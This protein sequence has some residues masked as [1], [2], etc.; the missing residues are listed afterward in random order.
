MNRSIDPTVAAQATE[1]LLSH[2]YRV[3]LSKALNPLNARD[4][5]VI[6]RR[7]QEALAGAVVGEE[8]I[9]IRAALSKLDVDWSRMTETQRAKIIQAS[10]SV[11]AQVP[12][13]VI[14]AIE[15]VL[16]VHGEKIIG[17]TK[18]ATKNQYKLKVTADL[19][20]TDK[21][22]L[23][24]MSSNQNLY[25]RDEYGRRQDRFA[26]TAI[27][28]VEGG[29]A[30][31]VGRDVIGARLETE[32]TQQGVNK[33]RSYWNM[34]ASTF[35][36]RSRSL[37]SLSSYRDSGITT[38]VLDVVMDEVTS[39]ICRFLDGKTFQVQNALD[40]YDEAAQASDPEDINHIMPWG[41]LGKD[42][43]GDQILYTKGQDGSQTV[44]AQ[45]EEDASGRVDDPGKF[46]NALSDDQLEEMGMTVPP[47]HGN[48]RTRIVPDL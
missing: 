35:A 19:S 29:L 4:Y 21:E 16:N 36:N 42:E 23:K 12:T 38:Y 8:D 24:G 14:P 48:C 39:L 34:L 31:G 26:S 9:A 20:R 10:S 11:L 33:S 37:G 18:V 15:T 28:I 6:V 40:R 41:N 45:V 7:L 30:Q 2:V 13:K 44:I 32:L 46:K 22:M 47:F 43:N 5:L 27:S 17:G 1:F 25:V 3:D